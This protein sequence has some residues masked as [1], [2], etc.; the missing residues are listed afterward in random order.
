[1][2]IQLPNVTLNPIITPA[3]LLLRD[4]RTLLTNPYLP[5]EA[6]YSLNTDG[7][8][9]VAGEAYMPTVTGSMIDWWSGPHGNSTYIGGHHL[10]REYIGGQLMFLR[11]SFKDPKEYFGPTYKADFAAA[12]VSTAVCA[13]VGLW[14]GKTGDIAGV[15]MGH[16]IHLVQN[17]FLGVR[18]RSRFWLGDFDGM[19]D[20]KQRAVM[21]PQD[22]PAG[23]VRHTIEEM[24]ILS[25]FLPALYNSKTKSGGPKR[26]DEKEH[27]PWSMG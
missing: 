1:M 18:M 23:L 22:M 2:S 10:V 12:N 20:P 26:R 9:N 8:W 24:S 3:P 15:D 4:A 14:E 16:V 13:R 7:M 11:I 5:L 21:V 6:G 19:T 17:E 25:T 27:L